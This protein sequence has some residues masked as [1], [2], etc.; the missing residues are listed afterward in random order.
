MGV[1]SFCRGPRNWVVSRF[2]RYLVVL[3]SLAAYFLANTN[4]SAAI[5]SCIRMKAAR[6]ESVTTQAQ[7]ETPTESPKKKCK[8]CNPSADT[9][10]TTNSPSSPSDCPNNDCDDPCCPCCPENSNQKGCPCPGGCALCSVAKTPLVSSVNLDACQTHCTG[11]CLVND[12]SQY[13]SPKCD[14]LDRPPRA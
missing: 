1:L 11:R 5:Q 8:H 9:S 2:C 14:G 3:V 10:E 4:A 13:I 7:E 12:S 6:T